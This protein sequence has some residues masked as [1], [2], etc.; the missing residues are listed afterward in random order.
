MASDPN[1][2]FVPAGR[3]S[4]E[5]DEDGGATGDGAVES[6]V[7]NEEEQKLKEV[8]AKMIGKL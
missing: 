3:K 7:K 4:G 6:E 8:V 5:S 2:G 1:G